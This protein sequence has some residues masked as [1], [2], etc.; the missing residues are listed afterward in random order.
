MEKM[1]MK[2]GLG[3]HKTKTNSYVVN[4]KNQKVDSTLCIE[5]RKWRVRNLKPRSGVL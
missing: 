3:P 5:F 1:R 2:I 4:S